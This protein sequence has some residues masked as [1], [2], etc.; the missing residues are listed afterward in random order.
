M[1]V[2]NFDVTAIDA[3][4]I[5]N[6]DLNNIVN[7]F[8]EIAMF[9]LKYEFQDRD[10][11]SVVEFS[12][13]VTE[14]MND[15]IYWFNNLSQWVDSFNARKAYIFS[16]LEWELEN[17]DNEVAWAVWAANPTN[18]GQLIYGTRSWMKFQD[19]MDHIHAEMDEDMKESAMSW[20][21]FLSG[22]TVEDFDFAEWAMNGMENGFGYEAETGF[23]TVMNTF[24]RDTFAEFGFFDEYKEGAY[25]YNAGGVIATAACM[26][27][28]DFT[29][30]TI[31]FDVN[32]NDFGEK[33]DECFYMFYKEINVEWGN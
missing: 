18:W 9:F 26:Q 20:M 17:V 23:W 28:T 19:V 15:F 33:F 7:A 13:A 21:Q 14:F 12:E 29:P 1:G 24:Y 30:L 25:S 4:N 5:L 10:F 22:Q 8:E 31:N 3:T 6:F 2:F 16:Q 32:P 27:F 11:K